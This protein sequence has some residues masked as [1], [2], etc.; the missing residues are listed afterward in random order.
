MRHARETFGGARLCVPALKRLMRG[1]LD[2]GRA[3]VVSRDGKV[4]LEL[5]GRG[6]K[7]ILD[8]LDADADVFAGAVVADRIVGRAAAAIYVVGRASAVIAPVVSQGAARL[9]GEH[10]VCVLADVAVPFIVNRSGTGMCP[11]DA[12]TAD[13]NDPSAIVSELRRLQSKK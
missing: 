7:P 6:V 10:G 8:A 5:E 2:A 1:L 13:L 12:N 11:M 9:L 4:V 3:A